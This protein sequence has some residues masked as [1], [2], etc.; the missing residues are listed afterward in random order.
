MSLQPG[1]PVPYLPSPPA[2]PILLQGDQQLVSSVR[3]ALEALPAH[4]STDVRIN[5]M[6]L[7]D[8]FSLNSTLGATIERETVVALNRM[9]ALW[10]PHNNYTGFSFTRYSES[11]PD[12]RL[13]KTEDGQTIIAMGIELKGWFLLSKEGEPSFRYSV[14]RTC[15]ADCDLL[16][17][18]PWYLGGSIDGPPRVLS[19]WV[20]SARYVADARN[21][22]WQHIRVAKGAPTIT[23]P[24][25][26][27]GPYPK[28]KTKTNDTPDKDGGGNFGRVP[29]IQIVKGTGILDEFVA[30][31]MATE[32]SGVPAAR[33][34]KFL[35][36]VAESKTDLEVGRKL[37]ALRSGKFPAFRRDELVDRIFA[38][39]TDWDD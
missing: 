6:P 18:V 30:T 24:D 29:R 1:A 2:Q 31:A 9:R 5:G 8:L 25:P 11:F 16:C 38:A 22:W 28:A 36:A 32:L 15:C 26:V 3:R 27:P 23:P 33:W 37:A 21:Y 17:V 7:P 39:L 35:L 20:K 12:V 13:E 4:F 19:P 10:D 14:T 34:Q